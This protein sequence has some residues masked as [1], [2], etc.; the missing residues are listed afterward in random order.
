MGCK[1]NLLLKNVMNCRECVVENKTYCKLRTLQRLLMEFK[2]DFSHE[3][4]SMIQ[5]VYIPNI[6]RKIEGLLTK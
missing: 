1:F 6:L 5:S 3:L 4:D 2:D